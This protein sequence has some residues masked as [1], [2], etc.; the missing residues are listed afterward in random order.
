MTDE[1]IMTHYVIY[2][3]PKDYPDGYVMRRWDIMNGN[4]HPVAGDAVMALTLEEVRRFIPPGLTRIPRYD[5]D[6]APILEVW[7]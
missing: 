3:H 1:P 2:D 7:L 4:P 6:D 5:S